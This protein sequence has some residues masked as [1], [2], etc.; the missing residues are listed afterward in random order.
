MDSAQ[1]IPVTTRDAVITILSGLRPCVVIELGAATGDDTDLLWNAAGGETC[2]YIAV[3]PDVDNE[4][5][6]LKAHLGKPIYF[7][8]AAASDRNG[9]SLFYGSFPYRGSGSI[10]KPVLH[11][12]EFPDI[13]FP[14]YRRAI[15]PTITL[16]EIA[17]RFHFETID[18][19]W[20]DVQGAEDL[21]IAG[22]QTALRRTRWL[23]T[24]FYETEIYER[25]LNLDGIH[26]SLPGN[27]ERVAVWQNDALF[28][29]TDAL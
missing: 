29:N 3:D 15:V 7:I 22:G 1:T 4:A 13:G 16:D 18:L 25:Q 24:E 20:C 19:V 27:W 28:R 8:H 5:E 2:R 26:K 10:K 12:S 11:L 17:D 23:H 9:L 14:A 21:V 6:F